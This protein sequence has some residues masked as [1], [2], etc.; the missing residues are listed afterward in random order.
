M[1]LWP[2]IAALIFSA[3]AWNLIRSDLREYRLPGRWTALLLWTGLLLNLHHGFTALPNAVLGAVSGYCS[4]WVIRWA[5]QIW[6]H[7]EGLGLGD[8]KLLGAL[9]AWV[10]WQRLPQLVFI[11]SLLG[12]FTAILLLSVRKQKWRHPIPFGPMLL[13]AGGW[14]LFFKF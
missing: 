8:C 9:G 7:R 11:A 12:L 6:K 10:G 5:F 13:L 14:I 2:L 1:S 4:F 3:I